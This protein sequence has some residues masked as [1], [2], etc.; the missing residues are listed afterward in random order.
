MPPPLPGAR[1]PRRA[2]VVRLALAVGLLFLLV[3]GPARAASA[4]AELIATDPAD[5][6]VV[7]E[8]P[9][10]IT[11][12]YSEDVTVQPDGV[13]VLDDEARRV[14]AGGARAS[15]D[16]VTV[17]LRGTLPDGSYVVAWRA[18]SADGHPVRGA[19]TF[20]V[21]ARTDLA[22]GLADQAFTGSADRRDEIAG[23]VLRAI[24]YVAIL[25]TSGAIWVG[26]GLRREGDPPPVGR[27]VTILGA[28]GLVAILL[29]VPVQASLATGQ[30]WGSLFDQGVLRIALDDG[31]GWSLGVT[32]AGL[33]ALLITSG[34]PFQGPARWF[35]LVGA[36]LAP[37]GLVITG[38]TRTMSPAA[39]GYLADAAHVVAAAVWFGGLLA[40]LLCIRRRRAADDSAGAAAA[41]ASFSGWAAAALATVVVAGLVLGWIEVGSLE[42]LTSTT[43]GR[44]LLVKV[45]LAGLV[46]A[47]GAWNRFRLVPTLEAAYP[48]DAVDA[49]EA[50]GE[51][52]AEPDP[53]PLPAEVDDPAD[54]DPAVAA[55]WRQLGGIVRFE[56]VGLVAVLCVTAVFVNIAPARS[57]VPGGIVSVEAPLGRGTME[58]TVDPAQVGRNDVHIYLLDADGGRE[59]RYKTASIELA[60]PAQDIG[61]IQRDPVVVAPGHFQLVG[62]QF[63]LAGE[64]TLKLTVKPDRFTE[65]V[66]EVRFRIR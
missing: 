8:A 50:A 28:V 46:I 34:L 43:Y 21:G 62:A 22:S 53:V 15:G 5:G 41:V 18:V 57:A 64:W 3:L 63:D 30:G 45:A 1:R 36:A 26:A 9:S 54:R 29:E 48:T 39:V 56:I 44:L 14:D 25:A 52:A 37:L 55:A 2:P 42:A 7:E 32:A 12:S 65:Q 35:A 13:R 31:V 33:I 24:A 17:P 38:H 61:P 49:P 4:H 27:A 51:E 40:L 47:A 60:L 58:V 19:F 59:T 10:Q 23:G 6:A 11:L 16:T 20:A 66:G